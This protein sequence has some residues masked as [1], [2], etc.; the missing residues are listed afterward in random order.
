MS[1][2]RLGSVDPLAA[3]GRSQKTS[4]VQSTDKADSIAVSEEARYK[5]ELFRLNEHVRNADDVRMDR[6][7]EVRKKLEDPDYINEKVLNSVAD[8]IMESFG[9]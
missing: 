6:I 3:Y 1:I 8:R 2:E 7:E 4:R 9:L 5:A